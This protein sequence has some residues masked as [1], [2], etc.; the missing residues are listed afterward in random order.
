MGAPAARVSELA[1]HWAEDG[2]EVTVLTGFPNHPTGVLHPAY[3]HKWRRL[4]CNEE[5]NGVR[6]VRSWLL[7]LPNR[8]P[9]ERILNYSS[10]SL[11]AAAT[12]MFLPQP[13]V[14]I[15]T[16][17]Q[18][19][20]GLA[21]YW[22]AARKRVPFVFEVRDLWPE[23]LMA[24]GLG[25]TNSLMNRTL[26]AIADFLYARAQ[27][28]VV[29][30]PA[31]RQ[32]LKERRQVDPAKIAV[33][34]NG[35]ETGVFR[36]IASS[37]GLK[38]SVGIKGKF[39]VGYIGTIGMAHGLDTLITAASELQLTAP[40]V[41]FLI[42]GEG[43]E[44]EKIR[45]LAVS[46]GLNNIV[47]VDQQPRDQIP[48]FISACD[49]CLV[50]LRK[51]D[52]FQTV[53]PSKMLEFM[54]CSRPVLVAVNGQARTIVEQANAGVFVEP[55]N[56]SALV[57]AVRRLQ[58]NPEMREYLGHNGRRHILAHYSRRQTATAYISLLETVLGRSRSRAVA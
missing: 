13:D 4:V 16:S 12:G 9:Y 42:V 52:L 22:L 3:R 32:H 29:V 10:F 53:I 47:F 18:L 20:V 57:E 33:I 49:A 48:Q 45:A 14:V 40:E 43:A 46:K 41:V 17:P 23:S 7:P 5:I 54:S 38:Q 44:K 1:Q 51:T 26:G 24:V 37:A 50:L 2:H 25:S 39:V 36:P 34:E 56:A 15:A 6:V 8:K 55:E 35:V 30:S 11:S 58:N 27:R 21:G 28:V 19:L 31:F